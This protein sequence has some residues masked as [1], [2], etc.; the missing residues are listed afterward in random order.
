[1]KPKIYIWVNSGHGTDWQVGMAMT[2][3]GHFL[4]S[5]ISS[6]R[7]WFRHD[8]GLKS[9][10]KHETYR[11]YYPDGYEL[12]EVPEGEERSHEGLAAAYA[13]NQKFAAEA[14]QAQ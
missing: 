10:W 11:E 4:A 8:M 2:E 3:D 14:E 13:L 6:C 7:D 12:V 1:V 5:H 9:D